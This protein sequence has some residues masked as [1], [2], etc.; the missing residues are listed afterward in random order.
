M[1]L[2]FITAMTISEN[3]KFI[4]PYRWLSPRLVRYLALIEFNS[5]FTKILRR[6]LWK[7]C[8]FFSN[9]SIYPQRIPL[10]ILHKIAITEDS[11][12]FESLSLKNKKGLLYKLHKLGFK[13]KWDLIL[14]YLTGL[15]ANSRQVSC[16]GWHSQGLFLQRNIF[17][18]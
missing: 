12:D 13:V 18:S 4:Y 1:D 15:V 11:Y 9:V 8:S 17:G 3:P 7:I 10:E 14:N 6:I 2:G 5:F 16:R